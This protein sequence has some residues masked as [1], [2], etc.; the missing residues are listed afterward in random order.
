MNRNNTNKINKITITLIFLLILLSY[1]LTVFAE[2]DPVINL[3]NSLYQTELEYISINDLQTNL[4]NLRINLDSIQITGEVNSYL[5]NV[6]ENKQTLMDN[7]INNA[8]KHYKLEE[9]KRLYIEASDSYEY[10]EMQK[11]KEEIR[12]T[13]KEIKQ[14]PLSKPT[15]TLLI[16]DNT[17]DETEIKSEIT[18][19]EKSIQYIENQTPLGSVQI[20]KPVNG[21]ITSKYGYR[22]H[23]VTNQRSLH[24]GVD[25][26]VSI[27]TPVKSIFNGT[28]TTATEYGNNGKYIVVSNKDIKVAYLHLSDYLVK[29]GDE[30]KQGQSIAL[31]GN[32]GRSTGPHLHMSLYIKGNPVDPLKLY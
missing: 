2:Q 12:K 22:I 28:V 7:K 6:T 26:A 17:L 19:L 9:L 15:S 27:G 13:V 24:T 4:T 32:T 5:T 1:P 3:L 16:Q 20:P 14:S 23:P 10:Q 18:K 29:V 30:V 11:L 8:I 21:N 25:Y 31:S